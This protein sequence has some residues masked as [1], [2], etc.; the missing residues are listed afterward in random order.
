[1]F[2]SL[3]KRY[4]EK[5]LHR[6]TASL[7]CHSVIWTLLALS[8]SLSASSSFTPFGLFSRPLGLSSLIADSG[9]PQRF[10]FKTVIPWDL[11]AHFLGFARYN[12]GYPLDSGR[13]YLI[14]I[15]NN[16]PRAREQSPNHGEWSPREFCGKIAASKV[17]IDTRSSAMES[18]VHG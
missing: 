4:D 5:F 3:F 13:A 17:Q 2:G 18:Q 8:P 11:L 9:N 14:N 6:R 1:M 12:G 10:E 7:M 15:S 16:L